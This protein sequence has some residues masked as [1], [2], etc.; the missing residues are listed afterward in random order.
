MNAFSLYKLIIEQKGCRIEVESPVKQCVLGL[1]RT[2][3]E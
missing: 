2:W 3:N 1:C